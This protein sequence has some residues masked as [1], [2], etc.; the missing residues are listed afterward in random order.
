MSN[1]NRRL[2]E[3]V[4]VSDAAVSFLQATYPRKLFEP[5]QVNLEEPP[6]VTLTYA[7]SMD[8]KIAG[9]KGK[10]LILSGKESMELT[11]R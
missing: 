3:D 2:F 1:N 10:Q 8:A 7:Q 11:H 5:I 4:P 6:F 9:A